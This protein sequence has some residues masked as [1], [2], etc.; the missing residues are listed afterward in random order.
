MRIL[1]AQALSEIA[2]KLG[3]EPVTIIEIDW[4]ED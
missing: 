2:T 1:N 3:T 4:V